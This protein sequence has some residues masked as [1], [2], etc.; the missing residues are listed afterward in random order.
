MNYNTEYYKRI[1]Q[2]VEKG[3]KL[4]VHVISR[5]CNSLHWSCFTWDRACV[6][7]DIAS[8]VEPTFVGSAKVGFDESDVSLAVRACKES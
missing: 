7:L 1:L 5:A 4:C 8:A 3:G 6:T 2:F